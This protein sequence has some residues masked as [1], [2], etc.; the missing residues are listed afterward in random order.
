LEKDPSFEKVVVIFKYLPYERLVVKGFI[1]RA[2]VEDN[3]NEDE[4]DTQRMD[5]S[6]PLLSGRRDREEEASVPRR[7]VRVSA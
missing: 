2:R 7:N 4:V 5:G 3:S 6:V 1:D